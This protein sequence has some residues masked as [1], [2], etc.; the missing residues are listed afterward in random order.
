MQLLERG[1]LAAAGGLPLAWLAKAGM[2]LQ[3]CQYDGALETATQGLKVLLKLQP[4]A[5]GPV[6]ADEDAL[7]QLRVIVGL[8]LL[9]KGQT[10]RAVSALKLVAGT[11]Q[12][13]KLGVE[14]AYGVSMHQRRNFHLLALL[15]SV[16][17]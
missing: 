17:V 8:S 2:Q 9:F 6:S 5:E 13:V 14:S 12:E 4:S 11:S 10:E 1:D 3:S 7:T 16:L 15:G